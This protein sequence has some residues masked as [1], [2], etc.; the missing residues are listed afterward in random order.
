MIFLTLKMRRVKK[1]QKRIFTLFLSFSIFYQCIMPHSLANLTENISPENIATETISTENIA[2]E[3]LS[4]ENIIQQYTRSLAESNPLT[5]ENNRT[6]PTIENITE[7]QWQQER[8]IANEYAQGIYHLE[9]PFLVYNPYHL[10]ELTALLLF[11][12]EEKA[13]V[14]LS[15]TGKKEDLTHHFE[16]YDTFHQIPVV[17][18]YPDTV[19]TLTLTLTYENATTESHTFEIETPALSSGERTASP[20]GTDFRFESRENATIAVDNNGDI[21]W[22]LSLTGGNLFQRLENGNLLIPCEEGFYEMDLLWKVFSLYSLPSV[23]S[24]VELPNGNFLLAQRDSSDLQELDRETGNIHLSVPFF[25]DNNQGFDTTLQNM[26]FLEQEQSILL[27]GS[28]IGLR[29]LAYPSGT[30]ENFTNVDYRLLFEETNVMSLYPSFW[31]YQLLRNKGKIMAKNL[32]DSVQNTIEVTEIQITEKEIIWDHEEQSPF[33]DVELFE[34]KNYN[35]LLLWGHC[36]E[37]EIS[38]ILYGEEQ[39]YKIPLDFVQEE[40]FSL[41]ASKLTDYTEEGIYALVLAHEE[42]YY[43]LA[44]DISLFSNDSALIQADLLSLQEDRSAQIA[45]IFEQNHYTLENPLIL[46]NPYDYAPLTALI[47]FETEETGTME[48]TIWGKSQETTISHKFSALTNR[49]FL[50]IYGLYSDWRNHITLRF[51]NERGE[52]FYQDI[53]I[54]TEP[55]PANFQESSLVFTYPEESEL[56]F[57]TSTYLSA[58]DQ[59]GEVRW[60]LKDTTPTEIQTLKN[61]NFLVKSEKEEEDKSSSFYEIDLLGRIYHEYVANGVHSQIQELSNGNFLVFAEQNQNYAV[62]YFFVMDRETG[63]VLEDWSMSEI[64]EIPLSPD[65]CYQEINAENQEE[66]ENRLWLDTNSV[67]LQESTDRILISCRTKDMILEIDGETGEIL[68]ILT[69]PNIDWAENYQEQILS[70]EEEDFSYFYGQHSVSYQED[71]SILL[72][73]NGPFR[74]KYP[75]NPLSEENY[76]RM[77]VYEINR[78]EMTVREKLEYQGEYSPDFGTVEERSQNSYLINF[79]GLSQGARVIQWDKGNEV[80]AIEL[81]DPCYAATRIPFY[82]A[83]THY[84]NLA[85]T[86]SRVGDSKETPFTV[87]ELPQVS[88]TIEFSLELAIDQGNRIGLNLMYHNFVTGE[89]YIVLD[90]GKDLRCYQTTGEENIYINKAGMSKGSYQ[91]GTL[92]IDKEGESYYSQSPIAL[93]IEEE[94]VPVFQP[95][96]QEIISV[97][98]YGLPT[99]DDIPEEMVYISF[100]LLCLPFLSLFLKRKKGKKERR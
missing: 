76:S 13:K 98:Y 96:S 83:D 87:E 86:T 56:L 18:L 60:Y 51:I 64:L 19:N 52:S 85:Y 59:K 94:E 30:T 100:P 90:S 99:L 6:L 93:E 53:F 97:P 49:H 63:Q 58:Y 41:I 35:Q 57:L 36:H 71:G 38:L 43:D 28:H 74:S 22:C 88:N 47:A 45:E 33:W 42:S 80:F 29:K 1:V 75:E 44:C 95:L 26:V 78:E 5:P 37:G 84:V 66:I 24:G 54:Q 40:H 46:L 92:V 48:V 25:Q 91:I 62:D 8:E 7:T 4:T 89:K 39:S 65:P 61:G 55:L 82:Q 3:T 12:S 81:S 79:G 73:D 9:N 72:F 50:P 32:G 34:D 31:E 14:S 27:Y 17:G 2:A 15:I 77:V 23:I 68:W 67:F 11:E 16:S 20:S 70:P 10:A 69:D 21:R